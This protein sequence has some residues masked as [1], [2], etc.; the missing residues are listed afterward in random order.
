MSVNIYKL[1]LHIGSSR[2]M[3][4]LIHDLGFVV[5]NDFYCLF[6]EALGLFSKS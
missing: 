1:V 6:P 4:L 5:G 2:S 3:M